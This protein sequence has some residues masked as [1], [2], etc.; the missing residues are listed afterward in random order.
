VLVL[1]QPVTPAKAGVQKK[2]LTKKTQR[3]KEMTKREGIFEGRIN[4]KQFW[5]RTLAVIFTCFVL[6]G[7]FFAIPIVIEANNAAKGIHT[8]DVLVPNLGV[9]QEQA[10]NL[11]N[12]ESSIEGSA[13]TSE[14]LY[15]IGVALP[16]T[17]F[18]LGV[19]IIAVKRLHDLGRSGWWALAWFIP[20]VGI[21]AILIYC[22]FFPGK[23][24]RHE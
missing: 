8:S 20:Y 22:G 21:P 11:P 18:L 6:G 9:N 15:I 24:L 2:S 13:G 17:A 7:I 3:H 5:L 23:E 16:V 10:V 4:R 14:L 19:P 12:V 1:S